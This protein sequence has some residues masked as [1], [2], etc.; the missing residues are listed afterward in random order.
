[1]LFLL[2][3]EVNYVKTD[4]RGELRRYDKY[5]LVA[6]AAVTRPGFPEHSLVCTNVATL[7][8]PWPFSS[9]GPL[10]RARI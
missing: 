3:T 6:E 8:M 2:L 9:P 10:R 5:T 7:Q 1:M 4:Y